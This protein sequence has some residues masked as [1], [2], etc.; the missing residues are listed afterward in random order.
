M[1]SELTELPIEDS[2]EDQL[3]MQPYAEKLAGLVMRSA[4]PLTVGI[5]GPWGQHQGLKECRC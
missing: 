1:P 2:R 4:F 5:Y 3:G